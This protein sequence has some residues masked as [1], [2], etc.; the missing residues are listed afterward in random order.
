MNNIVRYPIF[1]LL[2]SYLW[3]SRC[4]MH[5]LE[6]VFIAVSLLLRSSFGIIYAHAEEQCHAHQLFLFIFDQSLHFV[7]G[8]SF[9]RSCSWSCLETKTLGF[10]TFA[11]AEA[12][13]LMHERFE[14]ALIN[15]FTKKQ[16]WVVLVLIMEAYTDSSDFGLKHLFMWPRIVSLRVSVYIAVLNN[17][18]WNWLF[19]FWLN[20]VF[21]ANKH[22]I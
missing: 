5:W 13:K 9:R 20:L 12:A 17:V 3:R 6:V 19:T 15:W 7:G 18:F 22:C 1:C 2:S 11:K 4:I 14:H 8:F 21:S 16:S 10:C